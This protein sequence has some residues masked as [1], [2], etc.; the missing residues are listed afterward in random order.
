MFALIKNR[1][2]EPDVKA[3]RQPP[4]IECEAKVRVDCPRSSSKEVHSNPG[5]VK[6]TDRNLGLTSPRVNK[7]E[8]HCGQKLR[9]ARSPL[10]ARTEYA[11]DV[12][13]ISMFALFPFHQQVALAA[14]RTHS[15]QSKFFVVF[16]C[17][18]ASRSL[19]Y[20]G[21]GIFP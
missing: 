5:F 12:P 17:V 16:D 9:V 13:V 1:E 10:P 6:C 3:P 8:P 15:R 7:G 18:S 14:G 19:P 2:A 21:L 4:M 20:G 11:S